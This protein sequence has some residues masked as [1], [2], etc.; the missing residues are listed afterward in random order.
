MDRED[1]VKIV[2][3]FVI[4]AVFVPIIVDIFIFGNSLPSNIDNSSWAGFLGSY[5]GAIIGGG[6]TCWAVIAQKNYADK[7]RKKD[8]ITEIRP[9]IVAVE[10]HRV[11]GGDNMQ[12]CFS[13]QNI[14]LNSACGIQIYAKNGDWEDTTKVIDQGKYCLTVNSVVKVKPNFNFAE[15]H[16][17]E[18]HYVDLKSNLYYQQFIYDDVSD[19]F[20]SLEP[21]LIKKIQTAEP[22]S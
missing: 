14:G 11:K 2:L 1:K 15:T 19:S 8:E 13:I 12:M 10:P 17:F 16:F 21:K 20:T 6:C 3:P 9:Y 5:L 22:I 18:F 7:Q 4:L